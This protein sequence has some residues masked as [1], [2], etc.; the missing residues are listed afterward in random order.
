MRTESGL[1]FDG[2][3]SVPWTESSL[4]EDWD[5]SP[6]NFCWIKK[7]ET[8]Y[9]DRRRVSRK[10]FVGFRYKSEGTCMSLWGVWRK[11]EFVR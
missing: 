10:P 6:S 9:E 1:K 3:L 7:S 11:K 4:V 8:W 5:G 2:N